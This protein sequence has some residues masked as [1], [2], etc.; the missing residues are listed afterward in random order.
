MK[1]TI[2]GMRKMRRTSSRPRG[3]TLIELL[4]VIAIIGMFAIGALVA[5]SSA[6]AT[7]RDAM[8]KAE[9]RNIQTALQMFYLVNNRYPRNY[10]CNGSFCAAG[11]GNFGACDAPVPGIAGTDALNLVPLAWQ[12]SMQELVNGGF[13][14]KLPHGGSY[15]GYCY[16]DFGPSNTEAGAIIM[17]MFEKEPVLADGLPPSC[18]PWTSVGATWCENNPSREY[19]IC[20]PY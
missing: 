16:Y 10:N 3:F 15:S 6:R 18:R 7:A 5:F 19:C 14:T 17:T 4:V 20:N 13:L 9:F 2:P 1:V 12:M 11:N 8:R